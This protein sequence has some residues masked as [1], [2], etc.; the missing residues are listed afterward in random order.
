MTID[1]MQS[2]ETKRR[3]YSCME[4]NYKALPSKP[5]NGLFFTSLSSKLTVMGER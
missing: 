2:R 5:P 4:G 1:A 3:H